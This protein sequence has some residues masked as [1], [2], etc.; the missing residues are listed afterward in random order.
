MDLQDAYMAVCVAIGCAGGLAIWL[1][2]I[3]QS[4]I[5]LGGTIGLIPAWFGAFVV[6]AIWPLLVIA[7]IFWREDVLGF[8]EGVLDR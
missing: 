6:G 8:V 7:F 2:A 5:V 3:R 1:A 4:G